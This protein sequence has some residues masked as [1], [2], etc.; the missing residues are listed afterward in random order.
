[1][2][3]SV[4]PS[5]A[6]V[7]LCL[8]GSLT[9]ANAQAPARSQ[10]APIIFSNPNAKQSV[11]SSNLTELRKPQAPFRNLESELKG[12]LNIF[13]PTGN[14]NADAFKRVVPTAPALNLKSA[15]ELLNEEAE[16]AYLS[17]GSNNPQNGDDGFFGL[18]DKSFDPYKRSPRNSLERY[19]DRL[20]RSRDMMATNRTATSNPFG[21]LED[22]QS[23][24]FGFGN[25]PDKSLRPEN[26]LKSERNPSSSAQLPNAEESKMSSQRMRDISGINSP[27][28]LFGSSDTSSGR[29]SAREERMEDF[30]RLLEG[31]RYSGAAR[32]NALSPA[33]NYRNFNSPNSAYGGNSAARQPAAPAVTPSFSST[34][35]PDP[36]KEF[37][38]SANLVGDPGK[39]EGLKELKAFP[40]LNEA[41]PQIQPAP[42]VIKPTTSTFK[43]PKRRF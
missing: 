14:E 38:K 27:K 6:G 32:N 37:V 25:K 24:K 20:D 11:V 4:C 18:E 28:P 1:M 22:S 19:Y 10:G 5:F 29:L 17:P 21:S 3:A 26:S 39:P 7:L 8:A 43:V 15:K 36:Q 42:P 16:A 33:D 31:P 23:D 30:K 34:K 9:F 2:K 40:S 13:R 35:K 41:P 12:P